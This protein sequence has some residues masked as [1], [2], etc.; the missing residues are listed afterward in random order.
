[1]QQ[2]L[3]EFCVV[4]EYISKAEN[5]NLSR[6]NCDCNVDEVSTVQRAA[7]AAYMLNENLLILKIH[8]TYNGTDC[9]WDKKQILFK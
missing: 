2:D 3:R 6:E 8:Y 9:T 1:M 5:L 7:V 4:K